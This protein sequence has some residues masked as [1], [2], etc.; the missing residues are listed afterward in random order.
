M[1]Q[2]RISCWI[3]Q[4]NGA[5]GELLSLINGYN[6]VGGNPV[7]RRDPSGMQLTDEDDPTGEGGAGWG[8]TVTGVPTTNGSVDL[9][10]PPGL[11]MITTTDG[12]TLTAA[13]QVG[14]STMLLSESNPSPELVNTIG[15]IQNWN[16]DAIQVNGN[17]LN[18][19][20]QPP[21]TP[22]ELAAV[23]NGQDIASSIQVMHVPTTSV[24]TQTQTQTQINLGDVDTATQQLQRYAT[25]GVATRVENDVRYACGQN[26]VFRS[27]TQ[28][29]D[30]LPVTGDTARSLGA[31]PGTDI[32]VQAGMVSPNTEGMSVSPGSPFNLPAFR[33]PPEF[34]G[35]GK[36]PVWCNDVF[37]LLPF[38]LQYSPASDNPL[39]HG[40]IEPARRST[41]DLYQA[42]IWATRTTWSKV[43]P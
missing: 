35:T 9:Q 28:A 18:V 38:G 12:K 33:R 14:P 21:G 24:A 31:R 19:F 11:N 4:I 37:I 22:D 40:F 34:G 3:N 42:A 16:S 30:G 6:Y 41:F 36:D 26:S 17:I 10:M 20:V 43:N 23:L 7:T 32:P 1:L 25:C 5:V 15:E 29:P 8:I 2:R 13:I 27:M 39:T